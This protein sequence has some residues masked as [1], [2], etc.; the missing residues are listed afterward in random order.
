[1]SNLQEEVEFA[2]RAVNTDTV[3]ISLGEVASMYAAK[4]LNI[5]PDFQRLFRWSPEKKSAFIESILIGIPIPPVFAYEK[6]NGTWEL[7]DGLQ[8]ISTVLE[9]MGILRDPDS[10]DITKAPSTLL[11]T[12]YLPSLEGMR[13]EETEGS[14][15]PTLEKSMQLFFR[16]ARL[17]FKF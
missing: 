9:F 7:I 16:R 10:S 4:E 13:W 14:Q 6:D 5:L 11:K 3:Q 17:T 15:A 12:K 8:R 1:M 2:K